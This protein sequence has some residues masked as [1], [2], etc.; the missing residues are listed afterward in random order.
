[1]SADRPGR[2][3]LFWVCSRGH[4][5]LSMKSSIRQFFCEESIIVSHR[6]LF[7]EI[8]TLL[9]SL[10][11]ITSIAWNIYISDTVHL[12]DIEGLQPVSVAIPQLNVWNHV[13]CSC[14]WTLL[15]DAVSTQ[16]SRQKS[17]F[18]IDGHSSVDVNTA[19]LKKIS[20]IIY[21]FFWATYI[22]V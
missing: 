21:Y 16:L 7:T 6:R 10:I 19:K 15:V 22:L 9:S 11:P 18:T 17:G 4:M 1:M 8:F 3:V 14:R 13:Q 2:H 5:L 20:I 12:N